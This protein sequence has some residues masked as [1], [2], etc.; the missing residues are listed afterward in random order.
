MYIKK[1]VLEIKHERVLDYTVED[2]RE[3]KSN[4]SKSDLYKMVY[5]INRLTT[6]KKE[7][8]CYDQETSSNCISN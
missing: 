1:S 8:I 3:C 6:G 7:P 4:R 5:F 2:L